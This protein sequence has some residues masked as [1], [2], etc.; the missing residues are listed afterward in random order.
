MQALTPSDE[1]RRSAP[2]V[3]G[4]D[5]TSL[6]GNAA[7]ASAPASSNSFSTTSFL[8]PGLPVR[9]VRLAPEADGLAGGPSGSV[10]VTQELG[11]GLVIELQFVPLA[12]GDAVLREAFQER[13]E[14]LGRTSPADWSMAVR[15]VPGGV[16]VLSGPL[17]ERELED[18]LDRAL[19][20]R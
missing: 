6:R 10:I 9:D 19:G 17:T 3:D 12:G 7:P 13:K 5:G 4:R 15:D 14:L 18:L 20:L 1:L 11:D 16:A 2:A 8:V